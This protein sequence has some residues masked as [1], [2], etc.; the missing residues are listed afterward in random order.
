MQK[1][2]KTNKNQLKMLKWYKNV[3]V[4]K[5]TLSNETLRVHSMSEIVSFAVRIV[6]A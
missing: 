6:M 4:K 1:P 5:I 3:K 2:K